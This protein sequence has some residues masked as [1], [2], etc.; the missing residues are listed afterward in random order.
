MIYHVTHT[1]LD[2]AACSVILRRLLPSAKVKT[3]FVDNPAS[4]VEKVLDQIIQEANP[5]RI[6]RPYGVNTPDHQ[7]NLILITDI[8]PSQV[9]AEAKLTASALGQAFA[10][11]C[12]ILD[13]HKTAGW[14]A[15]FEQS[16]HGQVCGAKMLDDFLTIDNAPKCIGDKLRGVG[17]L[18]IL[19]FVNAVDA[20][21]RWQT[22]SHYRLR[23]E[24][25]QHL[26]A[27]MG[28]EAFASTFARCIDYDQREGKEIV[29]LLDSKQKRDIVS[30]LGQQNK[31]E[32]IYED[33]QGRRFMLIVAT[34]NV[35]QIANIALASHPVSQI[36]P[37]SNKKIGIDYV[38]VA[39]ILYN[40]CELRSRRDGVDVS[41][42][43]KKFPEGGGHKEAAGF[44]YQL[45]E[46]IL[47]PLIIDLTKK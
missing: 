21:D 31:D 30:V 44:P 6:E 46:S 11:G 1:D 7:A 13:H 18:D 4:N 26:F 33:L 32:N 38:V 12:V 5:A 19:D 43:A 39:N 34:S 42:I 24:G 36:A 40:K 37:V 23:G 22:D 2:G 14:V 45:K 15:N 25:L 28:P 8:A 47:P 41:E 27:L 35:S 29:R 9:Y 16:V 20:Y 17:A 10:Y 3:F